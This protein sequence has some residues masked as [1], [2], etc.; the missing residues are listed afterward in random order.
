[1]F[2][3]NWQV[4]LVVLGLYT[5]IGVA[6][7]GGDA[8]ADAPTKP[9]LKTGEAGAPGCFASR[10]VPMYAVNP[11][12]CPRRSVYAHVRL[13]ETVVSAIPTMADQPEEWAAFMAEEENV[14]KYFDSLNE[15]V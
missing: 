3:H 7:S 6:A 14:K 15:S 1:M 13:A 12:I 11:T 10:T 5:V 9:D 4:V 2:P 8:P